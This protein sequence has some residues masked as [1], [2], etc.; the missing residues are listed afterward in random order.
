MEKYGR[1]VDRQHTNANVSPLHISENADNVKI[2][3]RNSFLVSYWVSGP[4]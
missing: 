4:N 1:L 3:R 2:K